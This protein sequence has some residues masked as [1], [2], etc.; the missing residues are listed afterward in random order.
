M[1]TMDNRF[2]S[3]LM[4]VVMS[5][6]NSLIADQIISCERMGLKACKGEME[7][8]TL[9]KACDYQLLY[10]NPEIFE[11]EGVGNCCRNT[12]I[13]SLVLWSM[14]HTVS[15]NGNIIVYFMVTIG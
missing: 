4:L 12:V 14:N 5:P 13:V 1:E 10:S 6:L 9:Q 7:T 3:D 11:S 15:C 2:R 8:T